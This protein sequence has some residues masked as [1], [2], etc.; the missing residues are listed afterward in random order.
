[1]QIAPQRTDWRQVW[2]V[3]AIGVAAAFHTGKA[4]IGLPLIRAELGLGLDAAAWV[5]SAFPIVGGLIGAGMGV[6]ISRT[7]ARK[8]V[9]VG[10]LMLAAASA[11]GSLAPGLP[12]LL[13]TRIAEGFCL[14]AVSI[15]AP[16]LLETISSLRDRPMAIAI[17]ST[18]MP[19]GM[20][21]A[22][23]AAPLLPV[24]GW[25]GLWLLMAGTAAV[26][27]L[28]AYRTLAATEPPPPMDG[29][30]VLRDLGRTLGATGPR[31]LTGSF[32][33]WATVWAVLT[34]F[35]PTLL[36]ERV[37][38]G[39]DVAGLL[40]GL[41]TAGCIIGNLLAGPLLR[42]GIPRWGLL[43]F[44]NGTV[45][46]CGLLI[47]DHRVD[48]WYAYAAALALTL[49]GGLIPTCVLGGAAVYAP[50]RRLIA[51]TLG[52]IM[53]GSNIG[54]I[55]GPVA[56]GVA[57]SSFGWDGAGLMVVAAGLLSLAM[58]L[59]FRRLG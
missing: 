17:W 23:M 12:A 7:G 57:V 53:Q 5:L 35:L 14:M 22:M 20:S 27:G 25:R 51:A 6:V 33:C 4:P 48:P 41:V 2:L 31:L 50:D 3:L 45:A 13:A 29:S 8:A 10:M 34:G 43:A 49:V 32:M 26:I 47:F 24:I 15:A 1:M 56:A 59:R 19:L 42:R 38:V 39:V 44:A 18:F 16:A 37:G 55:I 30:R 58:A 28:L 46:V 9:V 52:M 36:I 54:L 21:L 11:M 40:A